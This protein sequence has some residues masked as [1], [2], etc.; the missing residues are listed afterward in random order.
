[1]AHWYWRKDTFEGLDELAGLLSERDAELES[2][3]QYCRLREK[4]LRQES[5]EALAVFLRVIQNWPL[6]KKVEFV[7]WLLT[8]VLDH[9]FRDSTRVFLP[10]PLVEGFIRPTLEDWT[11]AMPEDGMP[12]RWKGLYFHDINAL[13]RAVELSPDDRLARI[14]LIYRHVGFVDYAIHHL[15]HGYIGDAE[16]DLQLLAETYA[17]FEG[18]EEDDDVANLREELIGLE[19]VV[20]L[21]IGYRETGKEM[22]FHK[23]CEERGFDSRPYVR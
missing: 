12:H 11:K 8:L 1:M 16:E 4:G 20:E 18:L 7:D 13:R 22:P 14:S 3:A 17:L 6:D 21:W 15:P 19:R 5:L 10:H 2:Y 23:Y 9:H